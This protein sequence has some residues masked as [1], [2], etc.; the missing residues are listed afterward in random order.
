MK[1][2]HRRHKILKL[3]MK[4]IAW[5]TFLAMIFILLLAYECKKDK[6]VNPKPNTCKIR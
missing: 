4:I 1:P 3:D 6:P 2:T 5:G